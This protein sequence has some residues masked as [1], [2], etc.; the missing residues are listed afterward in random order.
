VTPGEVQ[1]D[2]GGLR[3]ESRESGDADPFVR[4]EVA[5][6]VEY[7]LLPRYDVFSGALD[8]LLADVDD[9]WNTEDPT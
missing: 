7:D 8:G 1:D 4:N 3:R 6:V 9:L 5:L 2:L